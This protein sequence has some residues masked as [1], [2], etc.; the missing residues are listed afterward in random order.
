MSVAEKQ[1]KESLLAQTKE[2]ESLKRKLQAQE[3][4]MAN[5]SPDE[6]DWT[7]WSEQLTQYFRANRIAP[8]MQ[9]STLLVLL[10][11]KAYRLLRSLCT[12][13]DPAISLLQDLFAKMKEHLARTPNTIMERYKFRQCKQREGQGI[14]AY[15]AELKQ[16]STFCGFRE[17]LAENLRDQ[18]VWGISG[19]KIRTRLLEKKG[20]TYQVAIDTAAAMETADRDAARILSS[21]AG[22]PATSAMT[23]EAA[24][25][26]TSLNYHATC[27]KCGKIGH[28]QAICRTKG[29]V[30]NDIKQNDRRTDSSEKQNFVEENEE[31]LSTR[32]DRLCHLRASEKSLK[33]GASVDDEP[34]FIEL[35]VQRE[36]MKFEI[37]TGSPITAITERTLKNSNALQKLGMKKTPRTFETFHEQKIIPVGIL[38]VRVHFRGNQYVLELFV[39]PGNLATSVTGRKWL[40]TLDLID[41]DSGNIAIHNIQSVNGNS[42]YLV[43]EFPEVF[44]SS[45]GLY[46]GKKCSLQLKPDAIPKFCKPRPVPYALRE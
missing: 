28:V 38:D 26:N 18:F 46:M 17:L 4:A 44:S 19:K 1:L 39:L 36:L 30:V 37:D 15:L 32:F 29:R 14:K 45:L 5:F 10:G 41:T 9:V 11:S 7:M 8:E 20:L 3:D 43:K 21:A 34:I 42:N 33:I 35:N 31:E 2:N 23:T 24:N 40:R 13:D 12:P 22:N 25:V 16:L 27:H 6:D